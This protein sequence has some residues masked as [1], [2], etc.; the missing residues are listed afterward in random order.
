ILSANKDVAG[1]FA[2]N[3][4]MALG[5]ARAVA[6][7]GR[8]GEVTIIS[9]DGIEDALKAIQSGDLYATVAQYPYAI[10][11]MGVQACKKATAG[12][13]LPSNITAPVA[14]VTKADADEALAKFPAPFKPFQNPLA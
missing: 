11:Q 3:D 1:F 10:G 9:V 7:A 5:I 14:V 6:D 13:E 12:D 8:T 4:D 2:A